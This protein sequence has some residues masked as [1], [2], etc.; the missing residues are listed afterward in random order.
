MTRRIANLSGLLVISIITLLSGCVSIRSHQNTDPYVIHHHTWWN[1]YQRGRLHLRDRNVQAAVMDF[2]TAL[3]QRPGARYPYAEDRWRVRTYGMHM[4][5]GYFPHRELG[6]CLYE[7]NAPRKALRLLETSMEMESS[8]RAKYY[9]NRIQKQ[10][11]IAAAPPPRI[12]FKQP[13]DWTRRHTFTL[14]GFALGSNRVSTVSINGEPEFSE[15]AAAR[16]PFNK[17]LQLKEGRNQIRI[18]AADVDGKQTGTNLVVMADWTPP[19]IHLDR[20][21]SELSITCKD[22]L[23][24]H[25]LRINRQTTFLSGQKHSLLFPITPAEPVQLA[26]ADRAGNWMEWSLTEK[27]LAHLAQVNEDEPPRLQ[28]ANAGKLITL[29]NPEY[30]LDIR[31]ED[32]TALRSVELNG[33]NLLTRTTPLFRTVRRVPLAPGTNHFSLAVEDYDGHRTEEHVTVVYR[34]PEYLDR[35]YRLA[36]VT[37]PVAGEIGDPAFGRRVS[38]IIGHELTTDPVRFYQL[39]PQD[40]A[41]QTEYEQSLSD[42]DL[43]DPRT[44]LKRGKR[45]DADLVFITRVLHD[46]PGQ[47]IYTRVLDADSGEELFIED[48]Y[49]EDPTLLSKHL[50]SLVMKIEQRFPLIQAKVH[51]QEKQLH[52]DAGAKSGA[53]KGMRFL[54][55]RSEDGPFEQGR[56]IHQGS[57]P[58]ELVVSKV[59]SEAAK[60]IIPQG[61][62]RHSIRTGD[63]VFSR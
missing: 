18:V 38:H 31:A 37:S 16:I 17:E 4:L 61:Q 50:R 10:L 48:I 47:T 60:V 51:G 49:L 13:A 55:I 58:A 1:Y 59:E 57:G 35:I 14:Q 25:Q 46:A 12:E 2:E 40:D 8:A 5:E 27:E 44:M 24:L 30:A 41:R 15:L 26:V 20:N 54:V 43:A 23:G 63:Y 39:A 28:L 52:I 33:E 36:A 19:E 21:G 32:D 56:V 45:L 42:S 62:T 34:Q 29:Y 9:I 6:I 53:H 3:G 11:A 22:N 7:M